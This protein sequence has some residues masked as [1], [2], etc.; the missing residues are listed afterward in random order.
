MSNKNQ[1]LGVNGWQ[2]RMLGAE[3]YPNG[4]QATG[5]FHAAGTKMTMEWQQTCRVIAEQEQLQ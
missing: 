3:E 2:E 4:L 5:K 1:Q